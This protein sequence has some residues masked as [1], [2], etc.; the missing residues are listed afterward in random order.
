MARPRLNDRNP[1]SIGTIFDEVPTLYL[2]YR[3][4]YPEEAIEALLE[5]AGTPPGGRILEIGAGP[6]TLTLPLVQRGF[7]V[8][9]V[10]PGPRMAAIL[11]RRL[12][13]WPTARVIESTFEEAAVPK[14]A[15]DLVVAATAFHWVDPERRYGLVADA[16]VPDGALA[17]IRNDHVLT[18]ESEAYYRGV[19]PIYEREFP[20]DAP[21]VPPT[22]SE[23]AGYT[24]DIAASGLFDVVGE[25]RFGWDRRYTA[26]EQVG[27]IR[28]YS[29]HRSLPARRRARLFRE[30]GAYIENEL[31][32]SFVDRSITTVSVGRLRRLGS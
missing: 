4:P 32:G 5:L 28:T 11:R 7:V 30:V 18:P 17:M 8:T 10:E 3:P 14:G 25:R 6:G 9:A 20:D 22:E 21:Y 31:G 24:D 26:Q 29:P 27:L 13:P 12:E 15:F 19:Q 16:L 1:R 23:L 2:R